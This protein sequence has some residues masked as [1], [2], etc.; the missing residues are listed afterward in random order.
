[1]LKWLLELG[2]SVVVVGMSTLVLTVLVLFPFSPVRVGTVVKKFW[3]NRG[4]IIEFSHVY[5]QEILHSTDHRWILILGLPFVGMLVL[6]EDY[7]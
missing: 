3:Q 4:K 7:V 1:M 5:C 6:L 2:V